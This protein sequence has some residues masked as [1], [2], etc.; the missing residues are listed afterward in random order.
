MIKAVLFD[1]DE[2]L[3][4]RMLAFDNYI[5][6]FLDHFCP[7]IDDAEF[8]KR[9]QDMHSTDCDGYFDRVE[10]GKIL[11]DKWNLGSTVTPQEIS[12]H[13]VTRFGNYVAVLDDSLPL[14]K[15]LKRRGY[16]VGIITNGAS[17]LQHT[18]LETSGLL[19]YLDIAVVSGDLDFKKPNPQI[20]IYTAD[21]LGL[22]PEECIYVG[23]HPINDI[24]GALSAGMKPIR[25]N[26]NWFKDQDLRADVPVIENIIDVLKFI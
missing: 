13:Y 16:K 4:D 5:K 15:E 11:I 2:T 21:K 1:F 25:F 20:F 22:K 9:R 14:I 6:E 17:I 3:Q 24:Q 10:W 26:F 19:D 8:E 18:K 7:S 23:D 12:D